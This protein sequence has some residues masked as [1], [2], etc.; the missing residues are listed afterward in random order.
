MRRACNSY[1]RPTNQGLS[2]ACKEEFSRF[3]G[4]KPLLRNV[5]ICISPFLCYI[6]HTAARGRN[7]LA[8]RDLHS[9]WHTPKLMKSPREAVS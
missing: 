7:G 8:S 6:L 1:G 4:R 3:T 2:F 9:M 5:G